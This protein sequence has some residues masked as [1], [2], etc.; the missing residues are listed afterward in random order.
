LDKILMQWS[1]PKKIL[2]P[3]NEGSQMTMR[4]IEFIC[5]RKAELYTQNSTHLRRNLIFILR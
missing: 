1:P 3:P 4:I 5:R 2:R